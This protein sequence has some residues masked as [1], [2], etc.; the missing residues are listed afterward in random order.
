MRT[1]LAAPR[2]CAGYISGGQMVHAR[3]SVYFSRACLR[4]ESAC[5]SSDDDKYCIVRRHAIF[6]VAAEETMAV[7]GNLPVALRDSYSANLDT[8][9]YRGSE[10]G[11]RKALYLMHSLSSARNP[12][13]E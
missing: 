13:L 3:A 7:G 1:D 4:M 5:V 9:G 10:K 12:V 8:V 2:K 6:I 11:T